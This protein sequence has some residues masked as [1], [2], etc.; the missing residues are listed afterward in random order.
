MSDGSAEKT[1]P[2][3]VPAE[4]SGAGFSKFAIARSA[5]L[6]EVAHR[7]RRR[8]SAGSAARSQPNAEQ[9]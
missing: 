3:R 1:V 8:R 5:P 2:A 9:Q 4:P 6:D 7:A